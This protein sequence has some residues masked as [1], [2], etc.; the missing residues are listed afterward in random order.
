MRK[1]VTDDELL[2][3]ALTQVRVTVREHEGQI[4]DYGGVIEKITPVSVKIGGA[5]YFR[6]MYCF[7]K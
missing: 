5:Y 3:A 1:I 4:A 6:N 7:T 2:T